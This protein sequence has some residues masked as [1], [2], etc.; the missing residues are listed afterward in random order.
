MTMHLTDVVVDD[1]WITPVSDSEAGASL[2]ERNDGRLT[3]SEDGKMQRR[4]RRP[5]KWEMGISNWRPRLRKSVDV[6]T[7]GQQSTSYL[8]Y[9]R[10]RKVEQPVESCESIQI[11]RY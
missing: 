2:E 7:S 5:S 4:A 6:G 3:G 8:F 9:V 11:R 10:V 1:V